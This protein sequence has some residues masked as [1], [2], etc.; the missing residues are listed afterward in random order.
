MWSIWRWM[1][2]NSNFQVVNSLH[3]YNPNVTS[4]TP[5]CPH[6]GGQCAFL[7]NGGEHCNYPTTLLKFYRKNVVSLLEFA[8]EFRSLERCLNPVYKTKN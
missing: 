6:F 4:S 2:S 5:N 7:G 8:L 3:S 1:I